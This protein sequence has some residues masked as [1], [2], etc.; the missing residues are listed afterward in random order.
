MQ[1]S[2]VRFVLLFSFGLS[3]VFYFDIMVMKKRELQLPKCTCFIRE[4]KKNTF[5]CEKWCFIQHDQESVSPSTPLN[6]QKCNLNINCAVKRQKSCWKRDALS[7]WSNNNSVKLTNS[8]VGSPDISCCLNFILLLLVIFLHP[9]FL[10]QNLCCCCC[11]NSSRRVSELA[12]RQLLL[13]KWP[14]MHNFPFKT[15]INRIRMR[16]STCTLY[17]NSQPEFEYH[18]K[19]LLKNSQCHHCQNEINI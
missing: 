11:E 7:E 12:S 13:V 17:F 19:M 9:H 4:E 18:N 15:E 2:Q 6:V 14:A 5:V 8:T 10:F 3:S 1:V 16:T